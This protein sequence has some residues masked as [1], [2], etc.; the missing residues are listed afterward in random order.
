MSFGL[1]ARK[2]QAKFRATS[3]T[4]S[5]QDRTPTDTRGRNYGHL[6]AL[7]YEEENLIPGIRGEQRIPH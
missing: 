5:E 1:D 7:G 2:Q 4:I 6:L 3:A